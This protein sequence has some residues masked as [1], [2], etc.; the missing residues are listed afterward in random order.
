MCEQG[1]I[2]QDNSNTST[3]IGFRMTNEF[4]VLVFIQGF[5]SILSKMYYWGNRGGE[6]YNRYL[7][8][9]KLFGC[10]K[11]FEIVI[12]IKPFDKTRDFHDVNHNYTDHL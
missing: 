1:I 8:T 11:G 6:I 5:I 9:T 3:R 12:K 7:E 2:R 4:D 10:L